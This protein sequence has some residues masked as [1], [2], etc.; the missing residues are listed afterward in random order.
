MIGIIWTFLTGNR[1]ARTIGLAVMAVLGVL[2]FG[3]VKKREGA[4]EARSEA[5]AKA[6]KADREAHERM[7]HA[8]LGIGATDAERIERL[9]D[10][11]ARHGDRPAEG[12]G[13]RLR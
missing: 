5:A 13:R 4:Q 6:A 8:D 7:N 2:T 9:R 10:F 12:P 3:A 1:I 11:A